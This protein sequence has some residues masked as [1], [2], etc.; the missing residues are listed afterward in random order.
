[1]GD[2]FEVK[3][4]AIGS[5]L[6]RGARVKAGDIT[7]YKQ[8]VDQSSGLDDELKAV[9]K[10]SREAIDAAGLSEP[11]KADAIDDL[12]KLTSELEK[13]ERDPGL[14]RRYWNRIKDVA[15]PIAALLSGAVSI[16]KLLNGDPTQ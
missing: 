5:A 10:Q 14:V 16:A 8:A 9:L 13:P 7:V 15:P 3:G 1:M 6:G 4:D 11:D 12:G 2:K